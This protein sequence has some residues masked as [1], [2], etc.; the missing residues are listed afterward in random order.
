[1]GTLFEPLFWILNRILQSK[2]PFPTVMAYIKHVDD[3]GRV[4]GIV[5]V[6]RAI[7]P[8]GWAMPGGFVEYNETLE[9]AV[10]REVREETGL[11]LEIERQFH[12]Y[13]FTKGDQKVH[14]VETVFIG[15]ARGTPNASSDAKK[16]GVFTPGNWPALSLNQ[17]TMLNEIIASEKTSP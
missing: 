6:D 17:Q 13:S 15:R 12:S 8:L 1:M 11:E 3:N 16:I 7:P 9:E 14:T 10:L 2:Y 4:D 5:L